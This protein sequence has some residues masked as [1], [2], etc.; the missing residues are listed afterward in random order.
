M[1]ASMKF[2]ARCVAALAML[3]VAGCG[4]APLELFSGNP[5]EESGPTVNQIV[6][7]I[8]CELENAVNDGTHPMLGQLATYEFVGQATLTVDVTDTEGL[9]PSLNFIQ[10]FAPIPPSMM[11]TTNATLTVSGQLSGTQ[12]RTLTMI[13]QMDMAKF[14]HG[15]KTAEAGLPPS[16]CPE[17]AS[18]HPELKFDESAI[19]G[20]LGLRE[21]LEDGLQA[22]KA[23]SEYGVLIVPQDTASCTLSDMKLAG[24]YHNGPNVPAPGTAPT[25]TY[26]SCPNALAVTQNPTT[27]STQ[28]DFTVVEGLSGGPN[29]TLVH[30]KGPSGGGGGGGGGGTSGGGAGGQGSNMGGGSQGLFGFNRQAKD[31]LLIAFTPRCD[32]DRPTNEPVPP[33]PANY[34]DSLKGCKK[35]LGAQATHGA[36]LFE[37][38][39]LNGNSQPDQAVLESVTQGAMNANQAA[40]NSAILQALSATL[41]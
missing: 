29:W 32:A 17:I 2:S 36:K 33:R 31:T 34:L 16:E 21:A 20:D 8:D 11:S 26:A 27:F 18:R 22:I 3:V 38:Y 25:G 39:D 37:Q 14:K 12:H 5:P 6:L 41:P 40:T 9:N 23:N 1:G 35:V 15:P 24:S 28:T 30:F 4:P 19:K 13:V 10:P 7:H